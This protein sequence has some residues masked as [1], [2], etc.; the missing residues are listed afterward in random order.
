MRTIGGSEDQLLGLYP[1]LLEKFPF[2]PPED[3][4]LSKLPVTLLLL[5]LDGPPVHPDL[6]SMLVL[7]K[8]V[9]FGAMNVP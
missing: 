1:P 7:S 6:L 8:S 2:C 4:S 9:G 5:L 3:R